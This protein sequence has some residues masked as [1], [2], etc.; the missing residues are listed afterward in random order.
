MQTF[1]FT[2]EQI[3]DIYDA[4]VRRGEDRQ[5]AYDWG[6]NVTGKHYDECVDALHTCLND[7]YSYGDPGYTDLHVVES[8]FKK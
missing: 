7:G 3:K 5:S 8:W 6:S 4:G 2:I 1:T